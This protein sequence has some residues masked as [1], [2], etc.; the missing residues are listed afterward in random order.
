MRPAAA[1]L[2]QHRFSAT[3]T[4]PAVPD[5]THHV[6]L[7]LTARTIRGPQS[8]KVRRARGRRHHAHPGPAGRLLR[9]TT[10]RF[11]DLL[12]NLSKG[13]TASRGTVVTPT[14]GHSKPHSHIAVNVTALG[15]R[16]DWHGVSSCDLA[17]APRCW[18][19]RHCARAWP[20]PR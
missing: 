18:R 4:A 16:T 5:R 9:H 2:P 11:L 20:R 3:V 17:T 1:P 7:T 6:D 14:P 13:S 15:R 12:G 19:P 10:H 8:T